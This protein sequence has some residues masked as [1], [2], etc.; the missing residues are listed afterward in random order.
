MNKTLVNEH[1]NG[2]S[3]IQNQYNIIELLVD[4]QYEHV[5]KNGFECKYC[6]QKK[7]HCLKKICPQ[8]KNAVFCNMMYKINQLL[9]V[10]ENKF[11]SSCSNTR[12][13]VMDRFVKE[14]ISKR[15]RK[16]CSLY[17]PHLIKYDFFEKIIFEYAYKPSK[18]QI[19]CSCCLKIK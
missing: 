11:T 2:S 9:F 7:S 10:Y 3:V 13:C 17:V 15:I 4:K 1:F 16:I 8:Y 5:F 18:Y 14:H 12:L 19:S 6:S